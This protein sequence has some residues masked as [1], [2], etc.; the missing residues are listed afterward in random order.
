MFGE[1]V[2]KPTAVAET[3]DGLAIELEG[4][5][6]RIVEVGQGDIRPST[7]VHMPDL[8]AVDVVCT[9][10]TPCSASAVP[11]AGSAG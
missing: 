10:S 4:H 2:V 8:D 7:V 11:V 3:L 5:E 1:R 9:R 6:L